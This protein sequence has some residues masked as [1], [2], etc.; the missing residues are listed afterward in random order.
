MELSSKSLSGTAKNTFLKYYIAN[1]CSVLLNKIFLNQRVNYN[2]N[3][4]KSYI[5]YNT[6]FFVQKSL[7]FLSVLY[8]ETSMARTPF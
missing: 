7:R 2:V 3:W 1:I 5:C 6:S 4:S 8:T